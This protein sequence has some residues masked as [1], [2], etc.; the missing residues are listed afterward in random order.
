MTNETPKSSKE[1]CS[2]FEACVREKPLNAL[3][4]AAGTG[5]VLG[6]LVRALHSSPQRRTANLLETLQ[7]RLHEISDYTSE[8]VNSGAAR[9]HDGV[10]RV[11]DLGVDCKV[12][13]FVRRFGDLFR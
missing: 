6:V 4:I 8:L 9:V 3:M 11:R 7:D 2:Q 12:S 10:E 1:C 13:S 5:I